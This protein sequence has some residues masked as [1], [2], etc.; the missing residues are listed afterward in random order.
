MK[1]TLYIIFSL[2]F[3]WVSCG[4]NERGEQE[5]N[6]KS[7]FI[8][9]ETYART[10]RRD[11]SLCNDS[12]VFQTRM[13]LNAATDYTI[14]VAAIQQSP[15]RPEIIV[16][17]LRQNRPVH[18]TRSSTPLPEPSIS[19]NGASMTSSG[20]FRNFPEKELLFGHTVTL[21]IGVDFATRSEEDATRISF[22]IPKILQISSP[23]VLGEGDMLPLCDYKSFILR[24]NADPLNE[25]GV[26]VVVEWYGSV[27][28]GHEKEGSYVRCYDVFP[29]TGEALLSRE[30]FDGIP[31]TGLCH[32]TVVRG[33][34]ENVLAGDYSYKFVGVSEE[35]LDFI[36]IRYTKHEE[37]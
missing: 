25:K 19:I 1:N 35:V 16:P 18:S 37:I 21:G 8:I 32:M 23:E 22:Y 26:V 4:K 13:E 5:Q 17:L 2:L 36:L 24:W 9:D 12:Q 28:F 11:T 34:V 31:D 3:L 14:G 29:D 33:N 20:I 30:M 15:L 10:V 7:T 6:A 27:I